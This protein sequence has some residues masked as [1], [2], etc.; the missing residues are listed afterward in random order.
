MEEINAEVGVLVGDMASMMGGAN[1]DVVLVEY[2]PLVVHGQIPQQKRAYLQKDTTAKV[3]LVNGETVEGTIR[4][5]GSVT[6]PNTRTFRVE[7]ELPN[8]EGSIPVGVSAE[9]RLPAGTENAYLVSPSALSLDDVGNIGVKVV[10]DE[11]IVRFQIVQL[12]EDSA[13]GI[14]VTGL[15]KT[16]RLITLGQNFV[17]DG[18]SITDEPPQEG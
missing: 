6:D 14:W 15:P 7:V 12:L 4:F 3:R 17:S 16:I 8:P 9:L 18:Q 1:A 2:D 11:N 5:I 10:D 13:D